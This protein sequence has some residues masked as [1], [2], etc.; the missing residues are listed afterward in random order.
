[1]DDSARDT[2]RDTADGPAGDLAAGPV[3][4]VDCAG[5]L[6]RD[7]LQAALRHAG[8]DVTLTR[9]EVEPV[10]TG[11]LSVSLRARFGLAAPV[12]GCPASVVVKL[13]AADPARRAYLRRAYLSELG[14]YHE[15]AATVDVDVPACHLA[16]ATSDASAFTL[17]LEDLAPAVP[18]DQIA[19]A[20]VAQ[21]AGAIRNLAGL[22]APR[23]CDPALRESPWFATQDAASNQGLAVMF[24]QL[25][26]VVAE[27]LGAALSAQDHETLGQVGPVLGAF[28][29]AR[30][31]RYSMI[32][33]DYR[34]DNLLFSP[35]GRVRAVDWQTLAVGLPARDLAYVIGTSL[36]PGDRRA[37]EA[38][39][40]EGYWQELARRGVAGYSAAECFEDYRLGML[41]A[42][43]IAVLGLAVGTPSERGDAMFAAMIARSCAAIRD[44]GTIELAAAG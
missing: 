7:W 30:P 37:A 6:T 4:P 9:L 19:G 29:T 20:T 5:D 41:Q 26:P 15:L 31:H 27:R 11:Q 8:H 12:A 21:V 35:D 3:K 24:P 32:H 18:G 39:L 42:P 17:I 33:G 25:V 38:S 22:H 34:L 23:W 40:V 43:F 10:G 28:F 1:M 36:P 16:V 13:P 14:F 44:L 2:A